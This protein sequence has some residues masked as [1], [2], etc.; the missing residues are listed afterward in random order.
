[1]NATTPSKNITTLDFDKITAFPSHCYQI[2]ENQTRS[3]VESKF[4]KQI[5]TQCASQR[6]SH[7]L[8]GFCQKLGNSLVHQFLVESDA[9]TIREGICAELASDLNCSHQQAE[10]LI[11]LTLELIHIK[12][13]G[14]FRQANVDLS[15]IISMA[16]NALSVSTQ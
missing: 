10:C 4:S 1:M 13:H 11:E 16:A 8:V 12:V 5:Q 6:D 15:Y 7:N 2:C 3:E 9:Y 14:S